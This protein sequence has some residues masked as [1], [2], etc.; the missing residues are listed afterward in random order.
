M[1]MKINS[2]MKTIG[3]DARLYGEKVGRGLG[4]YIKEVV[5]G[6]IEK[7]NEYNFIVFLCGDNYEEFK[8]NN[9]YVQKVLVKSRWYTLREQFELPYLIKKYK[10]DL[11]HFPHFN[12]PIFCTAPFIVTVHDLILTKFPTTRASTLHP[13]LYKF[14]DFA[15][16]IVI[17]LAI[18][19]S[20]K[21]LAVSQ[22]TKDDIVEQFN[23]PPN[24]I[25][26][27]LEGVAGRL[28]GQN[29]NDKDV[30]LR[31]NINKKFLLYVG[32]AYPHKNLEILIKVFNQI[33]KKNK[34]LSLV[35]VGKED[36]FFKRLKN[37]SL[38]FENKD[39][40]FPGFVP[41]DELVSFYKEAEAYVFPSLYEGFGLPP[42]EAMQ[43]GCPVLSSRE[44]CLPEMLEDAA[45]YFDAKDEIDIKNKILEVLSDQKLRALLVEKGHLQAAKFDWETCV[46][47]TAE[48]Y[49]KIIH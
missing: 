20:L 30:V 49:R 3:I 13:F 19:K 24:K 38:Q 2:N 16:R 11:M 28:K 33:S 39:I 21:I 35:I 44:S 36:Y 42:L 23:T 18:S 14:K 22:F 1:N 27:T 25:I 43:N 48:C 4:R 45:V 10:I 7:N 37:F 41:D 9:A 5:N 32:S 34:D 8:V 17:R 15:Y 31:Y 26:V 29:D 40:I 46:D 12:V 47:Q 6:V